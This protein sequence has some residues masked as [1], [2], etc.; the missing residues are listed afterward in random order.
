MSNIS[1]KQSCEKLQNNSEDYER[2]VKKIQSK[3]KYKNKSKKICIDYSVSGNDMVRLR[4]GVR[5]LYLS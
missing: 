1:L 4:K 2:T 3:N 5:L